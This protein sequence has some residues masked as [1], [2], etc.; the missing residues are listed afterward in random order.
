MYYDH[1][2]SGVHVARIKHF[3]HVVKSTIKLCDVPMLTWIF[4]GHCQISVKIIDQLDLIVTPIDVGFYYVILYVL[5]CLYS[6]I[7]RQV[8]NILSGIDWVDLMLHGKAK[9]HGNENV[10]RKP[11]KRPQCVKQGTNG[12]L[13]KRNVNPLYHDVIMDTMASQITSLTIVYSTV[14]SGLDHCVS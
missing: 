11:V 8:G 4:Y 2:G 10:W 5:W 1:K 6:Y 14:Y 9:P 12:R 13:I 3:Y 7:V